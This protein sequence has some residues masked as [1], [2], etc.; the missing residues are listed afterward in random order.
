MH[1]A[2]GAVTL[3][4]RPFQ[5]LPLC[6][7]FVTPRLIRNSVKQDPTTPRMQRLRAYTCKV[8]ALPR[9]LAAT[10]GIVVTFLS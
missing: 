5:I 4:G 10:Y 9:S 7:N 8:W 3:Y 6:M 1:F 2:Y